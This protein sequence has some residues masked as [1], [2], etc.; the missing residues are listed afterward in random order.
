MLT[1]KNVAIVALQ[2]TKRTKDDWPV[3]VDGYNSLE[4]LVSDCRASN[5]CA[6]AD[7]SEP[8]MNWIALLVREDTKA[9]Q[10]GEES[11]YWIFARACGGPVPTPCLVGNV[12]RPHNK[13]ASERMIPELKEQV[14]W[15]H[16]IYPEDPIIIMG[17]WNWT[18]Q[19]MKG[20]SKWSPKMQCVRMN[21]PARAFHGR[22]QG[23]GDID[24]FVVDKE[25]R[26]MMRNA[27]VS[28]EDISDH[29]PIIMSMKANKYQKEAL[30]Q[31]R[32]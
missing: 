19:E 16:N 27:T 32:G 24:H 22:V 2:E 28:R 13:Q 1:K 7:G 4:S 10:V 3:H 9:H 8:G 5:G 20:V 15:L 29:W 14:E 17:D 21:G 23:S 26:R 31:K 12:Y 11:G 25:H 30:V 6:K 18:L